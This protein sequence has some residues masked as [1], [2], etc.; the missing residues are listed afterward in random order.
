M[1]QNRLRSCHDD[2]MPRSRSRP[3]PTELI[4]KK[5]DGREHT[6]E[7]I[8]ALVEQFMS[9]ALAD[10]Q[11]SA[12]LMAA[13]VRG[14]SEKETLY[15]T[16]AMLGSGQELELRRTLSPCIDKHSTGGVG[17][18]LSIPLAP[19]V[20]ATGIRVPMIAGRGLGHTGGTLDKLE[21]IPGY[22]V[23]LGVSRFRQVLRKVGASII[24]QTDA[25]APADRRMYALRD[26]TGT[27]ESRPLIV[28]SILSKKLAAGLDGLVL[29][30][31]AGR[32]AFMPTENEARALAR[33]LVRVA[34][35]LGT[36][37]VALVT[38]MDEPLGTTIGNA[39]EVRESIDILR[40]QGPPDSTELT[41]RLGE[42]MLLLAEKKPTRGARSRARAR[43][44]EALSSGR[45]LEVLARM[46]SAHGGDPA[47]IEDP[48]RLPQARHL[49]AVR[50]AKSGIVQ[51]IDSRALAEVALALGAGRRR[52]ED[53]IDP[54][55]GVE[56]LKKRGDRV[57]R[58]DEILLLHA[59]T[60][61][62]LPV[63]RAA[64]AVVIGSRALAQLPLVHE[65]IDS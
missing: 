14:L 51:S 3:S 52:V 21:S 22:D 23:R 32:G 19:L 26:V 58:G 2:R 49:V 34:T 17:D 13:F 20:A 40:G 35:K 28:A 9:G 4:S 33:D 7:D 54:A 36:P 5:R 11:M 16:Q 1:A 15:L 65:R 63:T 43:L 59:R 12:W 10:Y 46:V 18:K 41:L 62:D 31:K 44:E 30:V 55:V 50:A 45:A 60:K 48:S 6:Q 38:N 39:L 29:D 37:T 64:R 25:I 47:V 61:K 24:G 27:V 8:A 53:T 57:A 56:L 42:E